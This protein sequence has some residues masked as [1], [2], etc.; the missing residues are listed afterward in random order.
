MGP[1]PLA[2]REIERPYP[3]PA[4]PGDRYYVEMVDTAGVGGGARCSSRI[5]ILR[6]L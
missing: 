1:K 6:S 5:P 3:L 2:P 4:L